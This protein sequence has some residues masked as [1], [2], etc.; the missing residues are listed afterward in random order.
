MVPA[1]SEAAE[2]R[3]ALLKKTHEHLYKLLDS[4][5]DLGVNQGPSRGPWS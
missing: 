2:K 1:R 5:V 3:A 4:A